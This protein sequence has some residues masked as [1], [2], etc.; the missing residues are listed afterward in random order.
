MLGLT[1]KI[2]AVDGSEPLVSVLIDK[3]IHGMIENCEQMQHGW[4]RDRSGDGA[5]PACAAGKR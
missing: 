5:P 2:T 1:K 3:R 4:R